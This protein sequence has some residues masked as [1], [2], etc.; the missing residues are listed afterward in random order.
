MCCNQ[1]DKPRSDQAKNSVF[2]PLVG[3]TDLL[4]THQECLSASW[5]TCIQYKA[6]FE[7]EK[8]IWQIGMW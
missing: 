3:A 4:V 1:E 2:H 8:N 5:K 6:V 7:E